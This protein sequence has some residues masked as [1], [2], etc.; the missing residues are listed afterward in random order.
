MMLELD[1]VSRSFV[2]S[3]GIVNAVR[4]VTIRVEEGRFVAVCGPSGCGK[5]TLLLLA[6]GLLRPETGTV[7]IAG[8][9]PYQLQPDARASFRG[10]HIGF[11][12]QQ[13]HLVPYLNV[14][15]NVLAPTLAAAG[16][17]TDARE[18]ARQL[19]E[20]FGMLHRLQHLPS[21]LSSGERQRTA[22]ARALLNQPRMIL[23]DEPTGNLDEENGDAVLQFL[24]GYAAEGGTVL[25]V[26]HDAS[27]AAKADQIIRMEDGAIAEAEVEAT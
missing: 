25:L 15:D 23:A 20:R 22:L 6:G 13:F 27:A 2:G 10:Q 17:S 8:T 18:R 19:L 26:T 21:Q 11:V 7:M 9:N 14:F 16:P 24:H 1:H 5:S 12:F 3:A 4:D